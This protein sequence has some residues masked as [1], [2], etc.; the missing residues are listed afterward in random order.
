MVSV[1]SSCHGIVTDKKRTVKSPLDKQNLHHIVWCRFCFLTYRKVL[2]RKFCELRPGQAG[3]QTGKL[4]MYFVVLIKSICNMFC[5]TR[6]LGRNYIYLKN[7]LQK[8]RV[9][10]NI[11]CKMVQTKPNITCKIVQ[12]KLKITCKKVKIILKITCKKVQVMI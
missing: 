8:L 4:H 10:S 6:N 2:G 1:S 11:I 9:I 3:K 12:I 5:R 7:N